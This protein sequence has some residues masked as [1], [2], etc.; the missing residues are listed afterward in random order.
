M[1]EGRG[2]AKSKGAREEQEN[3]REKQG[4]VLIL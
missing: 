1:E 3:R 4:L 2:K